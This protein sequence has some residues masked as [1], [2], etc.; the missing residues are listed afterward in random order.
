MVAESELS[1]EPELTS[2]S[3]LESRSELFGEEWWRLLRP[4]DLCRA[5][6]RGGWIMLLSELEGSSASADGSES[7][8]TLGSLDD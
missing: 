1:S 8:A 7:E 5:V 4:E 3:E 6:T 2:A